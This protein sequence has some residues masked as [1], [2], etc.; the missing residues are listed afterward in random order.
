MGKI[1]D[2]IGKKFDAEPVYSDKYI[3][4]K[5]KSYNNYIRTTFHGE[6]NSKKVPKE[7]CSY[8]CLSLISLDSVIR[9]DKK[10]YPQTILEECKH[11]L[12]KKKM[13][14]LNS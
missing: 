3:K 7:N 13:E 14:D 11:K 12:T 6:A 4:I 5:I 9:M 10:Y 8:K 2:L 1:R